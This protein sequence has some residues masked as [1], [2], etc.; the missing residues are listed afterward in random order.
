MSQKGFALLNLI[1][2]ALLIQ[3]GINMVEADTNALS[4][5]IIGMMVMFVGAITYE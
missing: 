2:G 4:S 1:L 5:M 3:S